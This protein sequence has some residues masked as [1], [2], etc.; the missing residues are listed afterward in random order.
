[1]YL[2]GE[3]AI[4]ENTVTMEKYLEKKESMAGGDFQIRLFPVPPFYWN[5]KAEELANER[6]LDKAQLKELK[7]H[8]VAEYSEKKHCLNFEYS[9]I[10][11]KKSSQL[12]NWKLSL[13]DTKGDVYPLKWKEV[14]LARPIVMG[15]IQRNPYNIEQWQGSGIGCVRATIPWEKGFA[16]K[17]VPKFVPWPFP[18]DKVFKWRFDHY[19]KV[20][21]KKEK[22]KV[23]AKKEVQPYRGW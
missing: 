17:V 20:V 7:A 23:E 12:K 5:K 21:G 11:F 15:K 8:Y 6:G 13:V 16:V 4:N 19:E 2:T 18:G 3:N 14:D 22:V 1:M 9:V 10:R